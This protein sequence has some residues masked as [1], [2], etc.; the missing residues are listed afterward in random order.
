VE[1]LTPDAAVLHGS[2]HVRAVSADGLAEAYDE[3]PLTAL[4]RRIEGVWKM[5]LV[6]QSYG[7]PTVEA[8]G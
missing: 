2:Y 8:E 7:E 5:T 3:V 6:H 1:V 4:C